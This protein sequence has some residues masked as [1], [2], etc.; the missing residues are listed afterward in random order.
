MLTVKRFAVLMATALAVVA[1]AM[2]Q[3]KQ[4]LSVDESY[5]LKESGE[6]MIIRATSRADSLEQKMVATQYIGEAIRRGNTGDDI[7]ATLKYLSLEGLIYQ[8]RQEGRLLNNFPPVRKE[9]AKCLGE[10]GS[11]E[12]KD[13]LIK[14][15]ITDNEPMVLVE[16]VKSLGKIGLNENNETAN[17]IVWTVSRFDILNPDNMLVLAAIDAFKQIAEKNNGLNNPSAIQLLVRISAST[18]YIKAVQERA[19]QVIKELM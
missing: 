17:A 16:V 12:A 11:P 1:T 5:L 6:T 14:M 13:A 4:E 2:G 8:S 3:D 7:L 19:K 10:L 9:T 18:S 15:C